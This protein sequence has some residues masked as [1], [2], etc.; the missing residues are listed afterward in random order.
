MKPDPTSPAE[1]GCHMS[2]RFTVK[3]LD[4]ETGMSKIVHFG[5]LEY[6]PHGIAQL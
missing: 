2:I 4:S 5:I 1:R 3:L 6:R